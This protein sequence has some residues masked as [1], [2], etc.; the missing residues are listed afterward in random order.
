MGRT[1]GTPRH[2]RDAD[3]FR[4]LSIAVLSLLRA[5]SGLSPLSLCL[6]VSGSLCCL[7]CLA[8][9]ALLLLLSLSRRCHLSSFPLTAR[10]RLARSL[11]CLLLLLL[12]ALRLFPRSACRLLPSGRSRSTCLLCLLGLCCS[13]NSLSRARLSRGTSIA[14]GGLLTSCLV[15]RVSLRAGTPW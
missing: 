1:R 10:L 4:R 9:A 5:C 2:R 8:C 11:A 6:S 14:L 15:T 12:T 3:T 13:A 7:T